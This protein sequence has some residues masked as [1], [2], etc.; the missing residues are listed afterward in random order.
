M[1]RILAVIPWPVWALAILAVAA[2]TVARRS[3]ELRKKLG[4]ALALEEICKIHP[5]AKIMK[6]P[7]PAKKSDPDLN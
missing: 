5:H 4:K 7:G 1:D 6:I 2:P 3:F